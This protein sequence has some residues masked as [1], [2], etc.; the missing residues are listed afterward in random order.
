M[1][2]THQSS[3]QP[4]DPATAEE[5]KKALEYYKKQTDKLSAENIKNDA[6]LSKAQNEL[7][8]RKAAFRLMV[9]L[10]AFVGSENSQQG[11]IRGILEKV[12]GSMKLDY[13][14][15]FSMEDSKIQLIE[16]AGIQES[17]QGIME[18]SEE[19]FEKLEEPLLV[20][21][22]TETSSLIESLRKTFGVKFY[23]TISVKPEQKNPFLLVAGRQKEIPPFYPALNEVDIHTFQ[24]IGSFIRANVDLYELHQKNLKQQKEK[25]ELIR[26]KKV[27]LEELVEKRTREL[28]DRNEKLEQANEE[29][30][31]Q[32]DSL[33][34]TNQRL[35]ATLETL[36]STQQKLIQK[37]KMASLG[38]LTAGIAHEIKNPLNFVNNFSDLSSELVGE[39][40]EEF[41]K[42]RGKIE[43]DDYEYVLE[44]MQDLEANIK[45]INEHG[46]RADSIVKGMLQHSRGEGGEP[47]TVNINK[48]LTEYVD[49][50][51]H[52]MRANNSSFNAD[53]EKELSDQLPDIKAVPQD[54]SRALLNIINNGLQAAWEYSKSKEGPDSVKLHVSTKEVA[55]GLCITIRDNG[56]GIP[57]EQ[58]DKIFEPFFTTKPTGE[59]TGL[60]LSMA[61]DII[62]AH[63]GDVELDTQ[64]GSYTE[65]KVFLP[66]N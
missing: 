15:L 11:F 55:N 31:N 9:E 27:E 29:I 40:L 20:N 10:Q 45:R 39:V 25:Q 38:Q 47:E 24:A 44:V 41:E 1:G 16:G 43:Q 63:K 13:C 51:Y 5:L 7:K 8:Q 4:E 33:I 61:Y 42:V 3:Q 46:Q 19:Y 50:A 57:D 59:G 64:P 37:E 28:S 12:S 6:Q 56:P 22:N 30:E 48:L 36:R 62:N 2:E 18:L 52:G 53:I 17:D 65:F 60:G 32:R 34:E 49:L 54:I 26:R 23:I 14:A 66:F 35:E 58:R 21:K